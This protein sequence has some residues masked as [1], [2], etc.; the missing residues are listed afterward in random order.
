MFTKKTKKTELAKNEAL[1][2]SLVQ[3][4]AN[5]HFEEKMFFSQL[6]IKRENS[7]MSP[8]FTIYKVSGFVF[9][10]EEEVCYPQSRITIL[11][12]IEGYIKI[13]SNLG[14]YSVKKIEIK[15]DEDLF[16]WEPHYSKLWE[17]HEKFMQF[18]EKIENIL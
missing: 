8:F 14:R 5:I 15:F 11:Y 18:T 16:V 7:K 2:L 6:S 4:C 13:K 17:H 12:E 3:F 1:T 9:P 10:L